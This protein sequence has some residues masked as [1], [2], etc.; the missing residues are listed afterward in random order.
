[1]KTAKSNNLERTYGGTKWQYNIDNTY[2][3]V[4]AG[5]PKLKYDTFTK[6]RHFMDMEGMY[7]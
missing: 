4:K 1:M 2:C 6:Q 5:L 3:H 7:L